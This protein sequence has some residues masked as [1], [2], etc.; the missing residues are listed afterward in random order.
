[1]GMGDFVYVRIYGAVVQ[2]WNVMQKI[3]GA[4]LLG[5]ISISASDRQHM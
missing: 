4:I 1:M 2:H 5:I 3:V